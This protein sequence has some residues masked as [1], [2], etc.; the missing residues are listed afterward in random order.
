MLPGPVSNAINFVRR[1]AR[2]Y[3]RDVGDAAD[4]ERHA[5]TPGVA[6]QR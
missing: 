3:H 4:V 2:R 1:R 6:E 5:V